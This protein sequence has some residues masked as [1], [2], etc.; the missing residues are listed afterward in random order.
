MFSSGDTMTNSAKWERLT[1]K[2][3][4]S[5]GGS[6]VLY[7]QIKPTKK[8]EKKG[9]EKVSKPRYENTLSHKGCYKLDSATQTQWTETFILSNVCLTSD[10]FL[11]SLGSPFILK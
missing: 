3:K 10:L 8:E 7:I 4:L 2:I 6:S 5:C 9:L 1:E 11:K